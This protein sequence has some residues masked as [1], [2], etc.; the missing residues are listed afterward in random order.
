MK[1]TSVGLVSS[2]M[3]PG[4]RLKRSAPDHLGTGILKGFPTPRT[5]STVQVSVTA[6]MRAKQARMA[7][8]FVGKPA[9]RCRDMTGSNQQ[10]ADVDKFAEI[11]AFQLSE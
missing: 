1:L 9:P 2:A 7:C 4:V 3:R 10:V 6:L 11:A 8:P 5:P